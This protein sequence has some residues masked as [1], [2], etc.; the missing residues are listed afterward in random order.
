MIEDLPAHRSGTGTDKRRV[1]EPNELIDAARLRAF[2]AAVLERLG[3]PEDDAVTVGAAFAWADLRG[4]T[5]QGIAKLPLLVGRIRA[6]GTPAAPAI[7]VVA[8][9]PAAAVLN[10]AGA[11]GQVAGTRAMRLAIV[12]ARATGAGIVVV[13]DTTSGSA[14]G[15]YA[16]LAADEGLVGLAINDTTPLQAPHGGTTRVLGN[17]A[18]AIG[19]PAAR[20]PT[21]IFDSATT[22]ISWTGIEA[23]IARGEPLTAG[24]ALD[25]SG[26]PTID[27]AAALAGILLPIGGH[28]GFGLSLMWAVLTGVLSGGARF[29]SEITPIADLARS[30][31]VSHLMLALD[32]SAWLPRERFLARVDTLVDQIHASPPMAGIQAVLVPG[33]RAAA[34]AA[35][36][37]RTGVPVVP[38]LSARLRSLGAELGVAW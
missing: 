37:E 20:C 15:W 14:M 28:R 4:I 6:G 36:R 21:V 34:L 17:Q 10:A 33:E 11:W 22:A 7:R 29:G 16:S 2:V 35:E 13:R 5:A 1:S 12:K 25:A 3:M 27:P 24:L 18:F 30:Q 31:S 9:T 8:E 38:E 19:A 26:T 32:P 23:L